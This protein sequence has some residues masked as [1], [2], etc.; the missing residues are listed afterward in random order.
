MEN[1]QSVLR[2]SIQTRMNLQNKNIVFTGATSGLGLVAATDCLA[3][4][5]NLI[6]MYRSDA[7]AQKLRAQ[8][9]ALSTGKGEL[10]LIPGDLSSMESVKAFCTEVQDR[11]DQ[12]D[13]LIMNAGIMNFEEKLS[14]DGIEETLQVNLLAPMLITDLLWELILRGKDRKVIYTSS[15]LHQGRINFDNIE[16]KGEFS[17]FKNYRQS[18]LGLILMARLF[19]SEHSSTGISFYTQHPGVVR[20]ELGRDAGWFSK[21]IFWLMGTTPEKGAKNLSYLIH[22][23]AADLVNGEYY[24]KQKVKSITAESHDMEMA[25]QLLEVIKTYLDRFDGG[26]SDLFR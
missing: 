1:E 5:A 26:K 17:S 7:S 20:T 2:D 10:T 23:D 11:I 4:G 3:K 9:E 12:V 19:A 6:A 8:F 22:T 15:G 25:K 21:L 13:Q 18:K 24:A 16:F 14:K